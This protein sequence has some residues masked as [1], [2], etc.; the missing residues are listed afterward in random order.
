MG[1]LGVRLLMTKNTNFHLR[2]EAEIIMADIRQLW[3][4]QKPDF[5]FDVR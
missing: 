4:V 1:Y 5:P 2:G 3:V